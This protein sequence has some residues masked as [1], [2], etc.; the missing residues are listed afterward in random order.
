MKDLHWSHEKAK[1]PPM[2]EKSN[3]I[4][5]PQDSSLQLTELEG[6]LIA[7]NII[8]QKICQLP[9]SRWTALTDR[10]INVPINDEDILNTIQLLPR[11]PKE[12]GL[13]GVALKR[14]LEYKNKHKCQLVNPNKI[15]TMLEKL[16]KAGN[17]YYQFHDDF[18]TY[19]ERCKVNDPE[20]HGVI[21]PNNDELK[22]N[23][24]ILP[25]SR[26]G[27]TIDELTPDSH[28]K[29]DSDNDTVSR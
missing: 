6:A 27:D 26:K 21:F 18:N 10:I 5:E 13:I 24:D 20:G 15:V 12:A 28:D 14:K 16:R 23:M 29:L 25:N 17:P 9:K 2:A 19:E 1:I 8:F 22:E 7:K 3:L 4:L 11:T